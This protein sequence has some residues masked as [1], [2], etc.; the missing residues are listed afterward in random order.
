MHIVFWYGSGDAVQVSCSQ[1]QWALN[2]DCQRLNATF[3]ESGTNKSSLK[4]VLD[5]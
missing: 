1:V 5:N 3:K 2:A 4:E